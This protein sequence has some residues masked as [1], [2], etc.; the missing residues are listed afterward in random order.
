M[1]AVLDEI[2][3]DVDNEL[4]P[5]IDTEE[6]MPPKKADPP[7]TF[8]QK[9]GT[10]AQWIAA[11]VTLLIGAG[12]IYLI[13]HYRS[14]DSQSKASDEHINSL[15]DNKLGSTEQR[16]DQHTDEQVGKL[17][18]QLNSLSERV[19]NL[20]G[21]LGRVS[22]L[23]SDTSKNQSLARL[24]DPNRILATIR[25]EIELAENKSVPLPQTTLVDYKNAIQTLPNSARSYWETVAAIINYQSKINQLSGKAPDP[26]RVSQ[27]CLF[28][29][30]DPNIHI[31][32]SEV[33]N[34]TYTNCIVDL[35][36]GV[37]FSHIV[38]RDSVIRY[39]GGPTHI[40][41]V[42]FVNCNFQLNVQTKKAPVNIEMLLA[43]LNS[44]NQTSIT[45]H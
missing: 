34:D 19:G 10:T 3:E 14:T 9:H 11:F 17:T 31:S 44:P 36:A 37:A 45:V 2:I 16:I 5:L 22:K 7:P 39:S 41:N 4:P 27:K 18:Q 43:L 28:L 29:T 32:N 25:T 33:G 21:L 40:D 23:E 8:F 38:F 30:S 13:T 42:R 20:Y 1:Q 12:N 15:I 6:D 26:A 35:D 24:I